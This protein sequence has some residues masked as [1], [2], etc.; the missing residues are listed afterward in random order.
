MLEDTGTCK[1]GYR[2]IDMFFIVA[3]LKDMKGGSALAGGK[4]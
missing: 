4:D 1:V 2:P 3:Y